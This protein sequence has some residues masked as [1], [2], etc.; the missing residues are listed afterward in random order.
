M[1][2]YNVTI[3][4]DLEVKDQWLNWMK[5]EHLPMVMA[6]GCFIDYKM[7]RLLLDEEDGETFAIQYSVKDIDTLEFYQKNHGSQLREETEKL[8][9]D[10]YVAIRSVLEEV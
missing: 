4:I 6:T 7:L 10:R 5:Q 1:I 2:I 9:K 8:F 3:K